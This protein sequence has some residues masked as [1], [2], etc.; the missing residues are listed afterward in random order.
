MR[1]CT[2]LCSLKKKTTDLSFLSAVSPQ[3]IRNHGF[4]QIPVPF[5]SESILHFCYF[6]YAL[7]VCYALLSSALL[8]RHISS[9]YQCCELHSV[10]F[11][12]ATDSFIKLVTKYK[13]WRRGSH[14]KTITNVNINLS[15][16]IV[17]F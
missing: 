14:T 3:I 7:S 15:Q 1:F 5:S 4:T 16:Q 6:F 8:T 13:L 12:F 9:V 10:F 11:F 17:H 2:V